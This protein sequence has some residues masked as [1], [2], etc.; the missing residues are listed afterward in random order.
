M[1]QFVSGVGKGYCLLVVKNNP[2]AYLLTELQLIP[3]K[4]ELFE[5]S[6]QWGF[7]IARFSI[8]GNRMQACLKK[9]GISVKVRIQPA[10]AG[11]L[12]KYEDVGEVSSTTNSGGET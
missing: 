10:S 11:V 7:F 5:Q 12:F 9:P 2:A 3:I 6:V 8:V 1:D 4:A